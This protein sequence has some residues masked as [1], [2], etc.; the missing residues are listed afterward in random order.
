MKKL[1]VL[2]VEDDP[3]ARELMTAQLGGH[4]VEFAGSLP[5]ARKKIKAGGNDIC[6]IDLKLGDTDD[7]SGLELIALA[8]AAGAYPVVMSGHDSEPIVKR[9]YE[10]GC[11]DFYAKGNEEENVGTVIARFLGKRQAGA[12]DPIF[13]DEFV[14]EDTETRATIS[15]TLEYAKSDMPVLIL[16]PSGSGKTS[17]A[18]VIHERSGRRGQFVAI[19]CAAHTEDLLEAELFGHRKGAFTGAAEAR[20]GKLL[21]ADEGT[22]FLDEVG[23]MSHKMQSKLLKAIEEKSFYP[24]GGERPETS[25]FRVIS[26]TLEDVNELV[27]KKELRF[28]FFQ[29]INGITL[30]LKPLKD[31]KGDI[32]PMLAFFSRGKRKLSFTED[33]EQQLLRYHWPGNARELKKFGELLAAGQTGRVTLEMVMELL[34]SAHSSQDSGE[35]MTDAMYE[36][37]RDKGLAAGVKRLEEEAISRCMRENHGEKKRVKADLKVWNSLLYVV[38]ER[39]GQ[40]KGG[41]NGE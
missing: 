33:A 41:K 36:F 32:L 39:L 28:D 17:L 31:R 23:A 21:L 14:T 7:H 25:R 37:I 24:L 12:D 3:L 10:L 27:R 34:T 1:T 4:A 13:R 15:R 26:A 40:H 19:N 30:T 18:R 8:V 35:L 38:L 5:A 6:F 11:A 2:I 16:G 20:K 9:A 29:R 22:L